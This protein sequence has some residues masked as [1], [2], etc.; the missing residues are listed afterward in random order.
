MQISWLQRKNVWL[1]KKAWPLQKKKKL[2]DFPLLAHR[3]FKVKEYNHDL[4]NKKR[5]GETKPESLDK[6]KTRKKQKQ[7]NKSQPKLLAS[8]S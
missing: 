5:K 1:R 3:D 2:S 7:T 6:R 4:K 8:V